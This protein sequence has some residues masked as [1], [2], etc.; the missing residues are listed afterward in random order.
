[1]LREQ[2]HLRKKNSKVTFIAKI[3]GLKPGI[4]AMHIHEKSACTAADGS[5]AGGHCNPTFK[6]QGQRKV[7]EYHRGDIGNFIAYEKGNG[8][9]TLTTAEWTIGGDDVTK[10]ILGKELIVPQSANHFD[11]QSIGNA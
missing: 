6:K 9:I 4:H 5:S 2:P 8:T 7:G 11:S 3:S 10:N 1:M